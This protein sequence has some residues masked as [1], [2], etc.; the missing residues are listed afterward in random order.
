MNKHL[1]KI[2]M[3]IFF[4]VSAVGCGQGMTSNNPSPNATGSNGAAGGGTVS[5]ADVEAVIQKAAQANQ[6]AANALI[7]AERVLASI[8]DANGDI[9][10]SFFQ[11]NQAPAVQAK[12]VMSPIIDKI[13]PTFDKIIAQVKLVKGK[14]N[15]ARQLLVSALSRLDHRDPSQAYL[16]NEI[17][18]QMAAIDKMEARFRASMLTVTKKLDKAVDQLDKLVSGVSSAI[19]GWGIII[20]IGLDYFVMGEIREYIEEVKFELLSL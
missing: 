11:A 8:Q 18:K 10:L 6:E 7:E 12:G 2:S 15:E 14:F 5:N 19:P 16:I 20:G 1:S 17:T 13:R 9:K 4:S 3:M